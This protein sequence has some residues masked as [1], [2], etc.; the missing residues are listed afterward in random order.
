M[1]VRH[2]YKPA[3][4]LG[5]LT[6]ILVGCAARIAPPD[7][8]S[9]SRRSAVPAS[10]VVFSPPPAPPTPSASGNCSDSGTFGSPVQ[11]SYPTAN[12]P[13]LAD[14]QLRVQQGV[15]SDMLSPTVAGFAYLND[16]G[17]IAGM[18]V[19]GYVLVD[20]GASAR[21]VVCLG[22]GRKLLVEL[23]HAFP[24]EVR[25]VWAVSRYSRSEP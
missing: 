24:N 4:V 16:T 14:Q 18:R 11:G 21:V 25:S 2:I 8:A 20:S 10:A 19:A 6:A 22:D 23:V 17:V 15:G 12:L 1:D 3:V 9:P 5:V 13:S 7:G